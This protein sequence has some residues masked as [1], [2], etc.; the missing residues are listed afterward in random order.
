MQPAHEPPQPHLVAQSLVLV[1]QYDSHGGGGGGL[2]GEG[3]GLGDGGGDGGEGG[4]AAY[5]GVS[6]YA[7][8]PSHSLL[9]QLVTANA[10]GVATMSK[11]KEEAEREQGARAARRSPIRDEPAG[12]LSEAELTEYGLTASA[13]SVYEVSKPS[14]TPVTASELHDGKSLFGI[15]SHSAP[16]GQQPRRQ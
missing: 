15:M 2:G 6:L 13:G 1:A 8:V 3:G 4:K 11:R 12:A 7:Q 9:S 16:D 14:T 5:V 10:T